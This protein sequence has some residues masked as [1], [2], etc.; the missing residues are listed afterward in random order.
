MKINFITA[1]A[2]KPN[3]VTPAPPSIITEVFL[4]NYSIESIKSIA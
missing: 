3:N 1:I 2:I 4:E